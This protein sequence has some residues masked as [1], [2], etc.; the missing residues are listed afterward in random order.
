MPYYSIPNLAIRNHQVTPPQIDNS[1]ESVSIL[2]N[3]A[4]DQVKS[5]DAGMPAFFRDLNL[6]QIVDTVTTGWEEYDLK[7]FFYF[8]P[9]GIHTIR[10]RHEVFRD[11]EDPGLY[12][13]I[14]RFNE[15]MRNVRRLLNL[16]QDMR[17]QRQ[18]ETWFLHSL[19]KYGKTVKTLTKGLSATSTDSKGLTALNTYLTEYIQSNEFTSMLD[20]ADTIKSN[21][22]KIKYQMIIRGNSFT[23]QDYKGCSDYS[24]KI[25][26]LFSKFKPV[27]TG[28][29]QQKY[30]SQPEEMNHIEAKILEF[31]AQLNP[32]IFSE[33]GAFYTRYENFIDKT[34]AVFDRE[35]HFYRAWLEHLSKFKPQLNF[36]YP[37]ITE[38]ANKI[39]NYDGFDLAL[40][41][42]LFAE[43]KPI[44]CN[45]FCL[46]DNERIMVVTGPNQGGK[47]TFARTF[48]QLHYLAGIGCP[49][50]G[51]KA[52]LLFYD[53]IFTQ[54]ERTERVENQRGKLEDDLTRIHTLIKDATPESV[55]IMNEIFNSTTFQDMKFL[56]KKIMEL[57]LDLDCLCVW[58]TFVDELSSFCEQT[59][60]RTSMVEPDNPTQRTYKILRRPAD[61]LAYAMAIAEK[62]DL[63]YNRI[64]ERI[65]R[66]TISDVQKS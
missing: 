30:E 17:D 16:I 29:Y 51:S 64:K 12:E 24:K 59:V 54:F 45:D 44:I 40:A 9:M 25:E 41:Q 42:K 27:G 60:S 49:I 4:A 38:A 3:D 50:P 37:Q 36:C 58:V 35:I 23:V 62:Y 6:D 21:L 55:I 28:D 14:D 66:E 31:V 8:K 53:R 1:M 43:D 52:Q 47:T 19:V 18:K 10:Y 7:P 32:R 20:E 15:G 22:S 5:Q 2:F 34:I 26:S 39:Y 48:G 13:H 65:N 63:T 57:I 61:G 11:L 56:S 46:E 33:L